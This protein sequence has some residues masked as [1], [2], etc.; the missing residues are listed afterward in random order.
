MLIDLPPRRA[1]SLGPCCAGPAESGWTA[2]CRLPSRLCCLSLQPGMID[3]AGN[4][5]REGVSTC[6]VRRGRW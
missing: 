4:A 2:E 3:G 1:G 6:V 5:P